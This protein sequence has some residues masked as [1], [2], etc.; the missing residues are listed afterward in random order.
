M[1]VYKY[2]G[3]QARFHGKPL[4]HI[5]CNLKEFGKG[6]IVTRSTHE[7]EPQH[8]QLPSFYRILWAQPLMDEHTLEGR[9]VAERVRQGVRY[10]DPVDLADLAPL[11]DFRLVPRDMEEE[12]CQWQKLRMYSPEVDCVSEPAHFTVPPLLRLLMER[13]MRERGEEVTPEKFLLPHHKTY[14]PKDHEEV[15]VS[16]K[17]QPGRQS[18]ERVRRV[19][20]QETVTRC[21]GTA[22]YQYSDALLDQFRP[23]EGENLIDRLPAEA[24]VPSPAVGMRLHRPHDS[25][26]K[27]QEEAR[28]SEH[29]TFFP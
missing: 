28:T 19:R 23:I 29:D 17:F 10:Q 1:P 3:Y 22:S 6:R 16:D 26:A 27:H 20:H 4:F 14:K 2:F 13:N 24:P 11:P 7:V 15:K 12:V 21:E 25:R 18:R 9:I 5:L 8:K